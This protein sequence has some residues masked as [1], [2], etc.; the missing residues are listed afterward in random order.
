MYLSII[1]KHAFCPSYR[2][3]HSVRPSYR[4]THS[5]SGLRGGSAALLKFVCFLAHAYLHG[6]VSMQNFGKS[7]L[8][9]ADVER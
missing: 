3:T 5:T 4:S 1:Q 6:Q 8:A 2:S 7:K 9:V